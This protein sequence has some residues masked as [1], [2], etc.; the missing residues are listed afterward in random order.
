MNRHP[1]RLILLTL[2]LLSLL[3][4][5]C[6]QP[7]P[8]EGRHPT[9]GVI[10]FDAQGIKRVILRAGEATEATATVS[11][12]ATATPV[13][14]ISAHP[15]GGAAGYHPADPHW[16]ETPAAAWG[17]DFAASRFGSTLVIST[18]NEISYIHHQYRLKD[19][20][21]ALPSKSLRLIRQPRQLNGDGA[22]D[23]SRP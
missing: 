10:E 2:P 16:R 18:K 11:E 12:A 19:I 8:V 14:K 6:A 7:Q 4:G 15:S 17:M 21:I 23:L 5:A 13:I 22:P 3:L 20:H 1:V 9:L